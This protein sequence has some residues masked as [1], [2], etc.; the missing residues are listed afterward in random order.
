MAVKNHAL[1]QRILE[2]ATLE[3]LEFGFQNASLRRIAQRAKLSTGAL[4]TRYKSKDALFCSIVDD[5]LSKIHEEFEPIRKKYMDAQKNYSVETVLEAI[6]QEESVYQNLLLNYY[7][8]CILF[9]CKSDGS[10]LQLQIEEFMAYK[11]KETVSYLEN[12]SNH[13]VDTNSIEILLSQQFYCYRFIL[14]KNL[15][16]ENTIQCIAMVQRFQEAGWKELLNA[17]IKNKE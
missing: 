14:E 1:D 4:Y 15:G 17:I 5:I 12:I 3:F 9:F 2:S 16:S 7:D 6:R 8:Q 13:K 10:S 11:A